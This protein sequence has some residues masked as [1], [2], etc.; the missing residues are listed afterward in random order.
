MTFR[1]LLFSLFCICSLSLSGQGLPI[2]PLHW[3]FPEALKT[4]TLWVAAFCPLVMDQATTAA[5]QREIRAYNRRVKESNSTL[6]DILNKHYDYAFELAPFDSIEFLQAQGKRYYLDVVL[7]PK[8]MKQPNPEAMI[9]GFHRYSSI[10]QMYNN[11]Y[12]QF[13]YYFYI[14]DLQ[15]G[16]AFLSSRLRGKLDAYPAMISFLKQIQK[17]EE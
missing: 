11:L 7:M 13:H 3:D 12:A 2:G 17:D 4:D 10:N 6:F 14:R 1:F 16:D 8:Q 9:P 15:D 5:Q